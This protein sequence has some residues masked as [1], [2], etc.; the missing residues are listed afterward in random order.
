MPQQSIILN[1]T[2]EEL[3]SMSDIAKAG[4]VELQE[5]MENVV[6]SRSEKYRES[7]QATRGRILQGLA[8]VR[9]FRS[10]QTAQ[11]H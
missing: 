11:K 8:D 1:K 6:R 4:N 5:I 3:A 2:E 7:H 9:T 10:R